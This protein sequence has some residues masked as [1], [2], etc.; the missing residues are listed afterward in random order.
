VNEPIKHHFLPVFYLRGWCDSTTGKLIQYSRP[1]RDV[2][3]EPRSPKAT[4]FE[5]NLYTM[6]GLPDDQKQRIEK[7]YMAAKVDDPAARALRVLLGTDTS[8]LTGPLREAW[9]RFMIASLHRRPAA[10]AEIGDTFKSTLRQNL[11]DPA[12]QSVREDGDPPTAFEWLEKHHPHYIDDAAKEM[13]VRATENDRIG[14]III[15][16]KWS[17]LDMSASR[18][19]LLTGD[20]P[21]LRYHGLKD[22]RCTILFPLTPTKLF[23]ATYDRKTEHNI[24]RRDKTE[25][26]KSV[27]DEVARI[28]E[29]L[30]YGRTAGHLR[31]VANRLGRTPSRLLGGSPATAGAPQHNGAEPGA[32]ERAP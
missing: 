7:D 18:H 10:V 6:E 9:T 4:G 19:E 30:V 16:M 3:A 13:V 32:D 27:N 5:P 12:Y 21:H 8:A 23:I 24:N 31:F 2:I 14:N 1:Y 17:T 29:R 15:N 11:D 25:V 28:A 22:P 26:V 20:M